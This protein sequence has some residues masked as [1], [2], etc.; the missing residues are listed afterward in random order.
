MLCDEL[1]KI[2]I[3][4]NPFKKYDYKKLIKKHFWTGSYFLNDLSG[5]KEVIGDAN[6]YPFWFSVFDSKE[7][8]K[9]AVKSIQ[10]NNLDKPFP[11]KYNSRKSK[12]EKMIFVEFFVHNWEKDAIWPQMAFVYI[13]L[14]SK[15]DKKKARFHLEQ[16]TRVI[17]INKNFL[18]VYDPN[19]KPFSTPF[20]TVDES[21]SWAVM[22]L[23]L[24]KR[25]DS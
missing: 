16:Y 8:L 11:L 23:A 4:D 6:I 14:L 20:Y 24:K 5:H 1:K 13:D 19:G 12:N 7:M 17:K 25:L 22:F 15:I 10:K 2:K 9:K 21:M 18:E 3:L